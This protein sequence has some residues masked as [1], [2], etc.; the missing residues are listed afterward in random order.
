VRIKLAPDHDGRTILIQHA[1]ERLNSKSA[2][3]SVLRTLDLS[4]RTTD[5]LSSEAGGLLV[6]FGE[7]LE[8]RHFDSAEN[9][10]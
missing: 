10:A 6:Q 3:V 5:T 9:T 7:V 4:D 8:E 2:R 1:Y